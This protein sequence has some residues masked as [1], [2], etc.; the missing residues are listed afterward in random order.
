MYAGELHVLG[1]G[2]G[3]DAARVGNGIELY[4]LAALHKLAHHYRVL[5]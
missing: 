1:Y 5:L 4:L 3:Q 2:V